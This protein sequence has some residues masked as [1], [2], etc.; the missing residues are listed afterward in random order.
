MRDAAITKKIRFAKDIFITGEYVQ[1]FYPDE[2]RNPF[3]KIYN[4]KKRDTI[5]I[6][7]TLENTKAILDVGGGMGR[8]SHALAESFQN[9]VVLTDISVDMLKLAAGQ[10]VSLMNLKYVNADAH[11]L[12]Y[13]DGSFDLVV[14][15]DLFCHLQEPQSALL[16]FYRVLTPKGI[17]II[18]STNSNSLWTLFYPRYLGRNPVTWLK[19][20]KFK[21]VLPGWETIVRHYTKKRFFSF[22]QENGFQI[23]QT[24]NYGPIV[25]PKWHLAVS[26]KI[27]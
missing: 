25:C 18:D 19:T 24:I 9:V 21:G 15:L 5:N 3:H 27:M 14:G 11:Q 8:L 12:P 1:H 16:E 22:L 4:R 26:K 17:L 10:K 6:I 20:I 23:I 2:K 7:N 13:H